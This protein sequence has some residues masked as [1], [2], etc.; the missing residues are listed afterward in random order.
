MGGAVKIMNGNITAMGEVIFLRNKASEGGA[1]HLYC[2]KVAFKGAYYITFEKNA[3]VTGGMLKSAYGHVLFKS[4]VRF[5][6]DNIYTARE[7]YI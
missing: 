1:I 7:S 4:G 6:W 3:A 5:W 2:S